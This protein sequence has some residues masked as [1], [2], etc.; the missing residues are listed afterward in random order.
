MTE[1]TAA[2]TATDGAQ[3]TRIE[4]L[5][6]LRGFAL[7]GILIVNIYQTLHLREPPRS[8]ELFFEHRFFGIFSLLFGIGF[9]IFLERAAARTD[10]PRVL[11]LRRLAVL[12]G[13]GG[14]HL[15]LQPG[16]V[17]VLYAAC[18][19]VFLLPASYLSRRAALA[20]GLVEARLPVT[21]PA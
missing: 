20:V 16:E 3:R 12:A 15:L 9:G 17:L 8:L 14:L 5:D 21:M 6:S 10:R 2:G 11:L 13:L 18:G 19:L 4:A 1:V 7:C